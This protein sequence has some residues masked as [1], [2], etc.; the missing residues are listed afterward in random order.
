MKSYGKVNQV[1]GFVFI[2]ILLFTINFFITRKGASSSLSRA[3]RNN[4][5]YVL[6][7]T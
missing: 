1:G 6:N 7:P 4:D 5:F 3:L 2:E